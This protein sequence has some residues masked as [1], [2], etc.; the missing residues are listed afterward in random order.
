MGSTVTT[1]KL[2]AAFKASSGKTIYVLFEQ[3]YEKNV[4][5]YVPSW[6]CFFIGEI[7][8]AMERIFLH[9]S[10]CESGMLQNRNGQITPEGYIGAWL[11]ELAA[12]AALADKR[13]GLKVGTGYRVAIPQSGFEEANAILAGVGR[14]DI[15]AVL[16]RGENVDLS[17]HADAEVIVAL[18]GGMHLAP[19]RIIESYERPSGD[20]RHPELGYQPTKAQEVAI[21]VPTFLKV[22]RENRLIQSDDGTFHCGGWE[23]SIVASFIAH[24][25]EAE[26][27]EPG[28]Y[29]SR[30]KAYREAIKAAPQMPSGM[31]V[32]V[33]ESV[34]LESDYDRGDIADFRKQFAVTDTDRGFAIEV[35]EEEDLLWKLTHLPEACTSWVLP[36]QPA[37]TADGQMSL[38]AA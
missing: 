23:Y 6:A 19:W 13:I 30:I 35:T 32:V 15:I 14:Q 10:S 26:L 28:S 36:D 33:D 37:S 3:T 22:D 20:V 27:R 31:R 21:S 34:P 12:P 5:P 24:A 38:L 8:Q 18:Y 7:E 1:G 16:E 29:R 11:K 4:R 17:L 2:A 25:W 9:A